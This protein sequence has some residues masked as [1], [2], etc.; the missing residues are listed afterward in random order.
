M[1]HS[2]STQANSE[3]EPQTLVTEPEVLPRAKRRQFSA[4]YKLGIVKE[5]DRCTERRHVGT[6]LLRERLYSSQLS[7]WRQQRAEGQLEASS[8]HQRER[9]ARHPSEVELARLERENERLRA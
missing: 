8:S 6:L 9:K 3:S 1:P 2:E 7:Q 5:A 4:A